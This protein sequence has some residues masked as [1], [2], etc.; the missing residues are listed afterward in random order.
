VTQKLAF[1]EVNRVIKKYLIIALV[2]FGVCC[3]FA[4]GDR[5]SIENVDYAVSVSVF[6]K[7]SGQ[8][9]NEAKIR[10]YVANLM[11]YKGSSEQ[12]LETVDFTYEVDSI[13]D[14]FEM[15]REET[16]RELSLAHIK[17]IMVDDI[18]DCRR[19][20]L[21][22]ADYVDISDEL[23]VEAGEE[24]VGYRKLIIWEE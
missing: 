8:H 3:L 11:E 6:S 19:V 5:E 2:I 1:V 4:D 16:G 17:K 24:T 18:P 22:L 7:W 20:L 14:V 9:S 21:E 12:M 13:S 23:K 10:L 15:Y